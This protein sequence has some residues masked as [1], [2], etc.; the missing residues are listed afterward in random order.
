[1][2]NF[3]RITVGF[4]I[5]MILFICC[6]QE[7]IPQLEE[8]NLSLLVVEG[9]LNSGQGPTNIHLSRTVDLANRAATK[10]ELG[11]Q[12]RVEGENGS[13]F[14][15]TGNPNG[16]YSIAQL[17]LANNVKYRLWI[18]TTDG[19]EYASDFTPIKYT[20][21]IDSI[22]WQRESDGVRLY[23]N[24]HDPQNATRYYQWEYEE[25]WEFH[26]A[27]QS[28]LKYIRN[29]SNRI[30]AV[31]FRYPDHTGDTTI[32]KCWKTVNST[33]ITLGSSERLTADV[34][35]LPFHFINEGSEQLSV[36]YSINLKQYAMSHEKYLFL[37]KMKKNTEQLGSLF[38][39]QPTQLSGNIHCLT[40][41]N[42]VVIGFVEISQ[43][44]TKRKFIYNNEVG[45][46]NYNP[47]C[48]QFEINNLPDSLAKYGENG[49]P[50]TPS[51]LSPFGD[52][53]IFYATPDTR[54]VDCT[55]GRSNKK[56]SFWP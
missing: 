30:I 33:S 29:T 56:P 23:V 38:D 47:Q 15:L 41:P 51:L 7:Y 12:V 26:S 14:T 37:E 27:F 8:K 54:C 50:T 19:K 16:E 18:K 6:K 32:Y 22:T 1:M 35:Y 10:S 36:L 9:F 53:I 3:F 31:V 52:I 45:N 17:A 28:S 48:L 55:I 40:Y 13:S 25:T 2:K 46:W 39:P 49:I 44:Q 4:M 20:P 11:A 24:T 21:P 5:I 42:E 43:Q 34:I